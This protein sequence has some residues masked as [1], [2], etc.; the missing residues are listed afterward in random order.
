MNYFWLVVVLLCGVLLVPIV[1]IG[2]EERLSKLNVAAGRVVFSGDGRLIATFSSDEEGEVPPKTP[3]T[4][5]ITRI[6]DPRGRRIVAELRHKVTRE[7]W[8]GNT[9]ATQVAL[10]PNGRLVAVRDANEIS[11]WEVSA[12]RRIGSIQLSDVRS[13]D[14][15][16][17]VFPPNSEQL[18][19][20]MGDPPQVQVWD[21]ATQSLHSRLTAEDRSISSILGLALSSDGRVLAVSDYSEIRVWDLVRRTSRVIS[22]SFGTFSEFLALSTDGRLLATGNPS[23]REGTVKLWDT[24]TLEEIYS[25]QVKRGGPVAIAPNGKVW[26]V[27]SEG[28]VRV[29]DV[30]TGRDISILYTRTSDISSVAFS[31]D[32]RMLA[33]ADSMDRVV[34]LWDERDLRLFD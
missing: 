5:V 26:V 21:I 15:I 18:L 25:Q 16:G 24:E 32:G 8:R 13:D 27:V 23:Y 20:V 3:T 6:W 14:D 22:L 33:I 19:V 9:T 10:S 28:K 11:V 31:P 4:G 30:A 7:R 2:W 12:A 34:K 17:V 1:G 29:R